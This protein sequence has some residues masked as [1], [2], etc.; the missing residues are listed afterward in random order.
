MVLCDQVNQWCNTYT[1]KYLIIHSWDYPSMNGF[2][3]LQILMNKETIFLPIP[4]RNRTHRF[5][6]ELVCFNQSILSHVRATRTC[7]LPCIHP[8]RSSISIDTGPILR[9][10][11]LYHRY[12]LVV[13][14]LVDRRR[15]FRVNSTKLVIQRHII[16]AGRWS[17]FL[18]KRLRRAPERLGSYIGR[19]RASL[20]SVSSNGEVHKK[21]VGLENNVAESS[22]VNADG[23]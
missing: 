16:T 18:A 22:A 5:K 1:I 2:E 9:L 10:W 19:G 17:L 7:D 23:G 12:D 11:L 15:I 14:S 21:K 8:N 13:I 3:Q 6:S 4:S 20:Q